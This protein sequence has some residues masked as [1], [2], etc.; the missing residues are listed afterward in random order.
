MSRRDKLKVLATHNGK[1]RLPHLVVFLLQAELWN[2]SDEKVSGGR[3]AWTRLP[4]RIESENAF[5]SATYRTKGSIATSMNSVKEF[6]ALFPREFKPEI[7]AQHE[8]PV[9]LGHSAVNGLYR[10][11]H[12]RVTRPGSSLRQF[13]DVPQVHWAA[14]SVLELRKL[15]I[16]RGYGTDYFDLVRPSL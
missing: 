14:R 5:T 4:I 2:W 1:P 8:D 16:M 3:A 9:A 13:N 7:V 12:L 10:L 11:S 15:G 6:S